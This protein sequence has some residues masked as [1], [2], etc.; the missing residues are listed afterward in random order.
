MTHVATGR[1]EL[2]RQSV[3]DCV[4]GS[5]FKG[6]AWVMTM[7]QANMTGYAKIIVVADSAG[8]K[9]RLVEHYKDQR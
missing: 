1:A 2:S 6:V 5:G 7:L 9:S 3:K 4:L 8:N